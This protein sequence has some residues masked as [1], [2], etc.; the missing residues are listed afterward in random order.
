MLQDDP[1]KVA[2]PSESRGSSEKKKALKSNKQKQGAEQQPSRISALIN[3]DNAS[4]PEDANRRTSTASTV[5]NLS[6]FDRRKSHAADDDTTPFV[7]FEELEDR[8]KKAQDDDVEMA[9]STLQTMALSSQ[10]VDGVDAQSSA[11][12][13]IGSSSAADSSQ[14]AAD[15]VVAQNGAR[16]PEANQLWIPTTNPVVPNIHLTVIDNVALFTTKL[17]N[18]GAEYRLLRRA[19]NGYVNATTLLL[20]GGV[21]TEQE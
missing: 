6:T 3:K 15:G 17:V 20:A 10:G 13:Q 4:K 1:M 8:P 7:N 12:G 18:P 11:G 16:E 9:S 21:E 5:S 19:D 14:R 2:S